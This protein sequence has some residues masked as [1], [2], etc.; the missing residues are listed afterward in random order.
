M[1]LFYDEN[2]FALDAVIQSKLVEA[3]LMPS[4]AGRNKLHK[5]QNKHLL[6]AQH[7]KSENYEPSL[8]IMDR[9]EARV[10]EETILRRIIGGTNSKLNTSLREQWISLNDE[11]KL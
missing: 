5:W 4:A 9:Y 8:H 3:A 6:Y 11:W 2:I 1:W 7:V 10:F